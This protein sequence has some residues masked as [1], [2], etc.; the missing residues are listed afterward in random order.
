MSISYFENEFR[1]TG[2]CRLPITD[3]VIQRGV[4]VFDSIRIYDRKAFALAEHLKRLEDSAEGAGIR[5]YG[6]IIEDMYGI[7]REGV[8]R[9]D[10]PNHGDCIV[11]AYITGG[12]VNDCG[13]FPEPRYFVIFEEGPAIL[14][15]EYATGVALQPTTVER[16][17]PLVKSINYL[18]GLMQSAGKANVLEC[19]Y[20]VDGKA[21]ETLR[22]SFFICKD[23]K[24]I[25]AP[26][27][28]VLGGVTR[29]IVVELARENGFQVEERCPLLSELAAA[30]EAFLTSS[31][32]EVIPVVKIGDTTIGNGKPGPV[33]VHLGKLYKSALGRWLD[34]S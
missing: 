14:A 3:L 33:A 32:K 28:K 26:V 29:N 19:L 1:P 34:K 20:C 27:G 2:D 23:G 16:P 8:K 10:C 17:Y 18:F 15:E 24:I 6:G 12:D 21:T 11:K 25:T 7:I 9:A 31:W 30:D 5:N 4:G 13:Y 22:S